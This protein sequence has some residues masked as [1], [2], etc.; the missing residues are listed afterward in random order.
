VFDEVWLLKVAWKL[1]IAGDSLLVMNE[2]GCSVRIFSHGGKGVI[3]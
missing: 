3:E 2:H 1:K